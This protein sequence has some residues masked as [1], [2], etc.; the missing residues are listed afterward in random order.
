MNSLQ[1]GTSAHI[2]SR[3]CVQRVAIPTTINHCFERSRLLSQEVPRRVVLL[4]VSGVQDK[5]LVRVHDRM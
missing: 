5:H 1:V 3:Q 2:S 4:K